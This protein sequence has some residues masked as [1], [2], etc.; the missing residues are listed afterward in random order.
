M[1]VKSETVL[2]WTRNLIKQY[3]IFASQK[4]KRGRP[5]TPVET[6]GLI[7]RMKNENLY[8]G[9]KRIQGELMKVGIYLDKNTISK[10][11]RE[12]RRKG[13]IRKS[14]TWAQFI[15]NH[16]ESLYASARVI[17]LR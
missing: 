13:K 4:K 10:I 12:Y 5:E 15:K 6:K 7:L 2:K 1:I 11:L 17:S 14:L 16:L 8:W 9:I 3:W